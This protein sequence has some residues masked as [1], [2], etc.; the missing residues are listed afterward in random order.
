ME[1]LLLPAQLVHLVPAGD[2][3]RPHRLQQPLQHRFLV[4]LPLILLLLLTA[5]LALCVLL[6]LDGELGQELICSRGGEWLGGVV[7]G[8]GWL[9]EQLSEEAR[10]RL[11]DG[12][13]V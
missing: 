10:C 4:R 13:L 9:G 1:H 12:G 3:A 11:E 6:N 7:V 8:R 5:L 2:S